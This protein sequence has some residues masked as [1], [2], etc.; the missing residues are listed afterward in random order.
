MAAS[1]LQIRALLRIARAQPDPAGYLTA[2]LQ[3]V[4]GA[5]TNGQGQLT[6]STVGGKSFSFSFPVGT[7]KLDAIETLELALE[8]IEAGDD[9]HPTT[10]TG[11]VFR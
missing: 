10:T 2:L 7:S 4:M 6:A 11:T 3:G 9:A 8:W 5:L 1:V